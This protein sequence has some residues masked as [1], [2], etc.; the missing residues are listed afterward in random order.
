MQWCKRSWYMALVGFC[1]LLLLGCIE[2]EREA[3]PIDQPQAEPTITELG[4]RLVPVALDL[5]GLSPAEVDQVAL[6]SYLVNGAGDCV[7]C[8]T[9]NDPPGGYLAGGAEFPLFPDVQGFTSVFARNLTPDPETGMRLTKDEFIESMRTGKDFTDSTAT[10]PQRL[11]IMPWHI[12]RF[13]SRDDLEAMFAFLQRIPPVRN[14]IRQTFTPPFPFPPVPFPPLGDGDPIND[15]TNAERGLRIPQFFSS[16]PAAE[17]FVAHVNAAVVGLT[18]DER[19]RVGRGSYLVNAIMSCNDCHTD[20]NGDGAFDV[21]LIPNT[22]D[23]NTAAYLAGGVDV[24]TAFNFPV[25][26]LFSRNLTPETGDGS[27]GLFL[28][29]TEFIQVMRFGADF[30]RPGGSLRVPPHFPVGYRLTLDDWQAVFAYL[31]IIPAVRN[32]VDIVP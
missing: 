2:D 20:G 19:A 5:T 21:G 30:R 31:Q 4:L 29:E 14:V 13:L 1:C 18:P 10:T 17:A 7:G 32:L 9:R 23:V 28:T 15:P 11:I 12:L 26:P 8:H 3:E 27:G 24:G 25:A 22:V 6:G 16:G